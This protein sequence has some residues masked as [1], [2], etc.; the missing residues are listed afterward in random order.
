MGCLVRYH[1]AYSNSKLLCSY[2]V[3]LQDLNTSVCGSSVPVYNRLYSSIIRLLQNS[4]CL[5]YSWQIRLFGALTLIPYSRHNDIVRFV[6]SLLMFNTGN[7]V[8]VWIQGMLNTRLLVVLQVAYIGRDKWQPSVW[9]RE[10]AI[11]AQMPWVT[12]RTVL[13]V[14]ANVQHYIKNMRFEVPTAVRTILLFL[15]VTQC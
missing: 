13:Q 12:N 14:M 9:C 15:V 8:W 7:N 6:I 2:W 11:N 5:K 1:P 4:N 3:C 10:K